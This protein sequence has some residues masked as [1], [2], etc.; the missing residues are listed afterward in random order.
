MGR[1][2]EGGGRKEKGNKEEEEE[3]GEERRRNECQ[4]LTDG[5]IILNRFSN[6]NSKLKMIYSLFLDGRFVLFLGLKR[7]Y[8]NS[9]HLTI[10]LPWS[11]P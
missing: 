10:A 8:V 1:R 6:Q 2:K 11:R 5:E 9:T 7:L 4:R 3:E